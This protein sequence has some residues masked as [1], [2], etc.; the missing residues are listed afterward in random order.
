[1]SSLRLGSHLQLATAGFASSS[2]HAKRLRFT[3]DSHTASPLSKPRKKSSIPIWGSC[4][5]NWRW[6]Q[7]AAIGNYI[8]HWEARQNRQTKLNWYV[9]VSN[10]ESFFSAFGAAEYLS[11]YL[12]PAMSRAANGWL[13]LVGQSSA[14]E[15]DQLT[16]SSWLC[17]PRPMN[18]A[19]R[20]SNKLKIHGRW[21]F[22]QFKM[23]LLIGW[24]VCGFNPHMRPE[25]RYQI[26]H[27]FECPKGNFPCVAK[28]Y[29]LW[30]HSTFVSFISSLHPAYVF[31]LRR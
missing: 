10:H 23:M 15:V 29:S 25:I 7:T 30:R 6:D 21:R 5:L 18:R 31:V 26:Y 17:W 22:I 20:I 11:A 2:T 8:I 12:L 4:C 9:F 24:Q 28:G 16:V 1:M 19:F 13:S 3:E 27:Y 14:D